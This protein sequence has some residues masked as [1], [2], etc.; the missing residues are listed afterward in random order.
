MVERGA[1]I[2]IVFRNG[3]KDFEV[4]PPPE[5][6][7]NIQTAIKPKPRQFI[8]LRTAALVAVVVSISF[9]AYWLGREIPS[10]QDTSSIALN[11]KV[12][13]QSHAISSGSNAK[14]PSIIITRSKKTPENLL[15]VIA[16]NNITKGNENS[17]LPELVIFNKTF[18]LPVNNTLRQREQFPAK[19]NAP[20]KYS[21][22][23]KE[24]DLQ[25]LKENVSTKGGRR[26]SIAAM[27]SPT[28]Y[29]TFKTDNSDMSKLMAASDQAMISY[30]G[31]VSFAYKM[32][33]RISV[34]SGLYYS[35]LG[36]VVN[37]IETYSG[38]QKYDYSKGSRNFEVLT[39]NGTVYTNNPDVFLVGVGSG[40][41]MLTNNTNDILDPKKANLQ[42]VSN[43]LQQNFSYVELPIIVRYKVI[44][45]II[46][47]NLIGGVSYNLL[48]SNSVYSVT[49]A[50]KLPVGKTDGLNLLTV[51]SSL[52]MGMEYNL[53]E[54][55]SLN[56]EPTFRYY[57]NP[58]NDLSGSRGHPYSFGVFSGV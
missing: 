10:V 9:V 26:W 43:T 14:V 35:S 41:K 55:F 56:L 2:D 4:I 40:T 22:T 23:I 44:D 20:Q 34:Q 45:K 11:E 31:G 25:D 12:D 24:I 38:F 6:W 30:T 16:D 57:L 21:F 36:Q 47:I 54:K 42:Y 7:D 27:A 33:K 50:G 8:L 58:F 29:S 5:V 18:T 51:S 37:G 28:Y 13:T 17:S 1:N 19:L 32:S 15:E 52:G 53:S 39:S 46:D 49:D 48:V 3:L